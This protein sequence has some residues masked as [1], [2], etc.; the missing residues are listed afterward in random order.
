M[1]RPMGRTLAIDLLLMTAG[2]LFLVALLTGGWLPW[3]ERSLYGSFG[4]VLWVHEG[5]GSLVLP[6]SL[7]FVA[8]H[9]ALRWHM[10][11]RL[12][13]ATGYVAV[14]LGA[15]VLGTGAGLA[16][17]RAVPVDFARS[18][19]VL[20]TVGTCAVIAVHLMPST[21]AFLRR[22]ARG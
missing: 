18:A 2:G 19:H 6:F 14:G 22:W 1:L 8:V 15:L 7:G 20:A 11:T 4:V 16:L 12:T 10:G 13:R 9:I 21:V 5:A 3:A 17:W